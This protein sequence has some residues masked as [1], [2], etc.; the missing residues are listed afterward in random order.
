MDRYAHLGPLKRPRENKETSDA[1]EEEPPA[2]I[3]PSKGED[4]N[5]ENK[6]D[7]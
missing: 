6:I 7:D 1:V 4:R 2:H 3:H 5:I